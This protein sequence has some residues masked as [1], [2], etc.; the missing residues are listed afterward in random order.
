[1][2]RKRHRTHW[3][4]SPSRPVFGLCGVSLWV[5]N[6]VKPYYRKI[7]NRRTESVVHIVGGLYFALLVSDPRRRPR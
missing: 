5:R 6:M 7:S 1:M 2:M 3:S 4:W